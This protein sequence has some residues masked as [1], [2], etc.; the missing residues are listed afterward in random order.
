MASQT[1]TLVQLPDVFTADTKVKTSK[2]SIPAV[3]RNVR[4]ELSYYTEPEDGEPLAP[5]EILDSKSRAHIKR[6][7]Q[8]ATIYDVR[9][10][11]IEHTLDK[12]GIQYVNHKTAMQDFFE[13]EKI[14]ETYYPEIS[15]LLHKM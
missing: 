8:P 15:D 4:T 2:V 11:G 5:I 9:G 12:S 13:D 10:S 7:F 3:P 6:D 1:E 14:K